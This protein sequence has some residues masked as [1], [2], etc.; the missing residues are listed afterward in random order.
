MQRGKQNAGQLSQAQKNP[1]ICK[2]ENAED[3]QIRIKRK[4][5]SYTNATNLF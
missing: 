5:Y 1:T 4:I 2:Q 3:M